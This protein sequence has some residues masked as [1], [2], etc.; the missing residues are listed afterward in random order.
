MYLNSSCLQS[1]IHRIYLEVEDIN[2]EAAKEWLLDAKSDPAQIRETLIDLSERLNTCQKKSLEYRKYQK[3]FRLD[4]TSSDVHR[5]LLDR[6]INEVKL[7]ITLWDSVQQVRI[8]EGVAKTW[9]FNLFVFFFS[10]ER[11]R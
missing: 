2:Q 1:D 3:E 5:R 6:V 11:R 4:A 10:V 9:I 8:Q 7:R